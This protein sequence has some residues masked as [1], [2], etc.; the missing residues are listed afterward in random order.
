[1]LKQAMHEMTT[2]LRWLLF[3]GMVLSAQTFDVA[4]VK[5]HSYENPNSI[6]PAEIK[7]VNATLYIT[8]AP[9]SESIQWAYHLQ[10]YQIVDGPKWILG[11]LMSQRFDIIAKSSTASTTDEF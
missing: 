10:S 11:R 8:D 5:Q 6:P 7:R 2:L 9:V 3:F 1:V 4:S